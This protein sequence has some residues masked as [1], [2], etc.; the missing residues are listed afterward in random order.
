[1]RGA[2]RRPQLLGCAHVSWRVSDEDA[3]ADVDAYIEGALV[4][5]DAVLEGALAATRAAGLPEIQVSP[6]QGKWL[7]LLA[8]AVGARRVLEVGT[9]AGYS[10]IWLA[11][12]LPREGRIVTL[13][14]DPR[15]AAVAEQ[16]LARAG[17]AQRAEVL[18][19]PALDALP[20][21]EGPFDLVF[22]DADKE[23]N[24]AYFDHALRLSRPGTVI[25]V[26]NVVREGT[27]LDATSRDG[28]VAG[29][30]RLFERVAAERRVDATAVQTVGSKG[31]DGF[32]MAVVR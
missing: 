8:K 19:G 15:H 5:E 1:M 2:K 21:L 9:L 30:R 27:V 13:E 16:N 29:T 32:L 11:R 28:Q 14:I 10:T 31:W 12:A 22:I 3:W 6:A 7:H 20:R 25:V 23:N 24:A 17:V 18:V 26:D 4:G